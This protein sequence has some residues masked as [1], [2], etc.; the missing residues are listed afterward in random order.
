MT[1]ETARFRILA[2]RQL[3]PM[4]WNSTRA[5]WNGLEAAPERVLAF[6]GTSFD[7]ATCRVRRYVGDDNA[8]KRNGESGFVHDVYLVKPCPD[9]LA[10]APDGDALGK[11]AK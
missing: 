6:V 5:K 4:R 10:T 1:S 11:V 8:N 9:C 2:W 3:K 7:C